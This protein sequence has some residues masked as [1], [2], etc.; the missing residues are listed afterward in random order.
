ML[1]KQRTLTNG[2]IMIFLCNYIVIS[3]TLVGSFLNVLLLLLSVILTGPHEKPRRNK[4]WVTEKSTLKNLCEGH[5]FCEFTPF[6][7][8]HFVLLSSSTHSPLPKWRT[9]QMASIKI[10]NITMGGILCDVIMSERSKVWKF[11]K[12]LA[13]QY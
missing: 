5:H 2:G 10:Y 4:D 12:S 3:G 7:L 8:C 6:F 1:Y 9:W 13:I 11:L